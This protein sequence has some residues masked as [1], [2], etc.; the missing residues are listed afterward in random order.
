V[1]GARSVPEYFQEKVRKHAELIPDACAVR[2]GKTM[3]TWSELETHTN[4]LAAAFQVR[5]IQNQRIAVLVKEPVEFVQILV[6]S[7]KANN[8]FVPLPSMVPD[9]ALGRMLEDSGSTCLVFSRAHRDTAAKLIGR[10]Q[11]AHRVSIG[12]ELNG[13]EPYG[14]FCKP[15]TE[16]RQL[17]AK[18]T[19]ECNLIYSSGTTGTPKGI[20]LESKYR[21]GQV[22]NW[23][24]FGVVPESR[25]MVTSSLY[26]NWSLTAVC[27][28]LHIGGTLILPEKADAR[29]LLETCFD[30]SPTHFVTV[31]IQLNRI[32]DSESFLSDS[33]PETLKICAGSPFPASDKVRVMAKWPL[34][35]VID[36]YGSTEGGA[37]TILYAHDHPD[38]LDSIG[39]PWPGM[40][41]SIKIIDDADNEVP[42]GQ[43]GEIVGFSKVQMREYVNLPEATDNVYWLDHDGTKYVR[44]GDIGRFDSDGYLYLGGRKKDMIISGGFNIYASDLED[45]LTS[46]SLVVEAAVIGISSD[47]WGES[48]HAYVVINQQ[49]KAS[50]QQIL[51]WANARLG[52][53]QRLIGLT[54]CAG[55][56][57][58]SMGKI[59]KQELRDGYYDL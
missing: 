31:P 45:V 20:M 44:S 4:E 19:D 25:V 33:M 9:E 27:A 22:S 48:P 3:V 38:K 55:L 56:P 1:A 14:E 30:T 10:G 8:C 59:V 17:D 32:L 18:P 5:G 29:S 15:G 13:C 28:T 7:L 43:S 2:S 40:E 57:R 34:G 11:L 47:R 36:L 58:N 53:A 16:Y 46:H 37:R 23:H 49:G 42:L 54:V 52:K 50:G 35:G 12:C 41:G 21:A 51:A 39:K 24:A 26:S 6:G